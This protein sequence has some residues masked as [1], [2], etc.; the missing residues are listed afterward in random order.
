M[1][2]TIGSAYSG[3]LFAADFNNDGY[4]DLYQSGDGPNTGR[5]FP[6]RQWS[7]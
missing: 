7:V 4:V 3:G 1:G 6:C 2:T 5:I